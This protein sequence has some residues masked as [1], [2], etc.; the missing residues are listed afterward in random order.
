MA[1]TEIVKSEHPAVIKSDAEVIGGSV[2]DVIRA[3]AIDQR[4][5][6]D[7]M[8]RLLAMQ[9]EIMKLQA[10]A[11]FRAAMAAFQNECPIIG[12]TKIVKNASGEVLYKYAPVENIIAQVKPLLLKHGFSYQIDT[13][14][15]PNLVRAICIV[16]HIAGHSERSSVDLPLITKTGIMSA[17][18]VVSGTI[19]FGTRRAFCNAFGI[20]TGDEDNDG[21]Y[22]SDYLTD[23]EAMQI[24]DLLSA[25][26]WDDA[27]VFDFLKIYEASSVD[28]IRSVHVRPVIA[29]L[30]RMLRKK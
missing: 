15:P 1:T 21:R 27:K 29:Y 4:V 12:K 13:E 7:K 18:Q 17:P 8:E 2:L 25:V 10:E 14:Y 9:R 28:Q 30:T 11:A 5:D 20:M 3:A 19:T 26:G 24:R 16:R 23:A 6:V 22:D